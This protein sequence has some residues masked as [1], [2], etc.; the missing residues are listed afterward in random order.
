MTHKHTRLD[1]DAVAA[2]TALI[3]RARVTLPTLA[4]DALTDREIHERVLKQLQPGLDLSKKSSGYVAKYFDTAAPKTATAQPP[5]APGG[6][7]AVAAAKQD[8][9]E[10]CDDEDVAGILS[11]KRPRSMAPPTRLDA[12]DDTDVHGILAG[13]YHVEQ[14]PR[15]Y[16]P[17]WRQH[18]AASKH[19]PA[20]ARS[21]PEAA[22][23]VAQPHFDAYVD[24]IDVHA[25][26]AGRVQFAQPP[27]RY[28]TPPWRQPLAAS[29]SRCRTDA[30]S[31]YD[32]RFPWRAP[33]AASKRR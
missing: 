11:G 20:A 13:R 26:L 8:A 31:H 6:K 22:P 16:A 19:A 12:I 5:T 17:E 25:I 4:A 18:L 7:P 9:G 1:A 27:R 2:R 33:L 23:P 30:P 24:N 29:S 15:V 32:P 10:Y 28:V 3:E 14:P 21:T